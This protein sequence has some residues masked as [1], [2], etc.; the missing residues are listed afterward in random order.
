M[1][2]LERNIAVELFASFLAAWPSARARATASPLSLLL[3]SWLSLPRRV[4]RSRTSRTQ[5]SISRAAAS[6]PEPA[7]APRVKGVFRDG[8][9]CRRAMAMCV[10]LPL[11]AACATLAACSRQPGR[12]DSTPPSVTYRILNNDIAATN[13]EAQDYCA[14]YGRAAT[15][16][17]VREAARGIVAVYTCDGGP[18]WCETPAAPSG[19]TGGG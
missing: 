2:L 5:Y 6:P 11:L 7:L 16:R 15:Y 9:H 14:Q 8:A 3:R 12:V 19:R 17:G 13:M 18:G 10:P 4:W 1:M